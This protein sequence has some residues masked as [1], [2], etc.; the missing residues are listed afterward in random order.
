MREIK[1]RIN[2]SDAVSRRLI[3]YILI[4]A[5]ADDICVRLIYN[6]CDVIAARDILDGWLD[7][8]ARR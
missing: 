1:P 7:S 2:A 3:I 6:L 8:L 5:K 4:G